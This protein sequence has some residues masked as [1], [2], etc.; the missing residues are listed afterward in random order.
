MNNNFK[1]GNIVLKK[2]QEEDRNSF[3]DI[4]TNEELCKFMAGGAYDKNSD[5]E[6]LF[7]FFIDLYSSSIN[8]NIFGIYTNHKLIGHFEI[9]SNLFTKKDEL[10]IVFLLIK[11]YW[12]KGLMKDII[13]EMNKHFKEKFIA[14]VKL[15]NNNSI[16]MLSKIG[17]SN[18]SIT[19][20][21]NE[22]VFKITLKK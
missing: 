13:E 8:T 1:I 7:I 2:Y 5:A 11:E 18:Q 9:S 20:F 3:I 17:I 22:K 14:R 6:K 21:N 16:K 19:S 15:N 12:G 10:E 4:F